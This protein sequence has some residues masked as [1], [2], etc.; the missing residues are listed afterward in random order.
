MS[1][2]LYIA[3][4]SNL[5]VEQMAL[6][7]PDA[8]IVGKAVLPDWK[9]CF[10]THAD[11]EPCKGFQVP[12]LVW[13]IAPGD[14][15]NLDHYEG[16]PAYYIKKDLDIAMT[17]LDGENPEEATAMVYVMKGE[18]TL[19]P[20]WVSYYGVLEEGYERFGFDK[21]ILEQALKEAEEA[22]R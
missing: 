20:P 2:R 11:I 13:E 7:C 22:G 6:R 14:E 5:S 18:H 10:K 16:Y 12:V 4:G 8:R 19:R 3:Y 1:R 21:K 15:V 17:G 9:L